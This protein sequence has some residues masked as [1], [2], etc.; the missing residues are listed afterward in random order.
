MEIQPAKGAVFQP[1]TVAV[2]VTLTKP[3]HGWTEG[4]L[5]ASLVLHNVVPAGTQIESQYAAV[6][7][8]QL[9]GQLF[10]PVQIPVPSLAVGQ[11][12]DVTLVFDRVQ[13]H[14]FSTTT[15]AQGKPNGFAQH[16]GW[17]YLYEGGKGPLSVSFLPNSFGNGAEQQIQIPK[18]GTCTFR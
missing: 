11:S 7:K 5:K 18:T 3:N 9:D 1:P 14:P 2:R 4:E 16:N 10:V 15:D 13:Q 17:C 8:T 6:P 12:A